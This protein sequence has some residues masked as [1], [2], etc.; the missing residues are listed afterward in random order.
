MQWV[1]DAC[2]SNFSTNYGAT[3]MASMT[4]KIGE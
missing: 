3:H 4:M 2:S 1:H